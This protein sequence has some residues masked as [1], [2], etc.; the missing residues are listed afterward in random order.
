MLGFFMTKDKLVSFSIDHLDPLGQGVSKLEEKVTFVNNTLPDE[1]GRAIIK[2]SS[3]GVLF[4]SLAYLESTSKDRI[5][6]RCEYFNEC[7]GC[8]Y[9]HTSYEKELEFKKLAL[10]KHI[11]KLCPDIPITVHPAKDRHHYRNRIQLHY[12]GNQIG[13]KKPF[14]QEI[15][16]INDCLLPNSK[17]GAELK[18]V[19]AQFQISRPLDHPKS[20]HVEIYE[21]N[22]ETH[23][24]WNKDY[25][26]GGFTQVNKQMHESFQEFIKIYIEKK[27]LTQKTIWDLF[28]GDGNLGAVCA[29]KQ[30]FVVDTVLHQ[31]PKAHQEFLKLNLFDQQEFQQCLNG[32]QC[33][34]PDIIILDPPRAGFKQV[35]EIIAQTK[36]EVFLAVSCHPSVL[37]R[38]FKPAYDNLKISEVHLFDFFP[39][40]YHFE[41]LIIY[42][43]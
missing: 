38:D 18:K 17:V 26:F 19:V 22:D 20:G 4:A 41:T 35:A 11:E 29:P 5:S 25:A 21:L 3:K 27:N 13:F 37:T 12:K 14:S 36:P 31:N 15:L 10:A 33:N 8:Q 43:K 23:I 34:S 39:G 40:T 9:L 24:N 2:K 7:G 16:P 42:S 6:T 32:M 30:H 1:K 28:G